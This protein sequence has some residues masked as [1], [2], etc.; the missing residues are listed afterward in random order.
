M[1]VFYANASN[2]SS[3]VAYQKQENAPSDRNTME[4]QRQTHSW[5]AVK[6]DKRPLHNNQTIFVK[7]QNYTQCYKNG[8][9]LHEQRG[10]LLDVSVSFVNRVSNP[11]EQLL[12]KKKLVNKKLTVFSPEGLMYST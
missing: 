8:L 6:K 12:P 3:I 9:I 1:R 2:R 7:P 10:C 4:H 5:C 11:S